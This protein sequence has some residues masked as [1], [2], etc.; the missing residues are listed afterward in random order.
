M[1]NW[2]HIK[3]YNWYKRPEA[4]P[5][6]LK[7]KYYILHLYNRN[8]RGADIKYNDTIKNRKGAVFLMWESRFSLNEPTRPEWYHWLTKNRCEIALLLCFTKWVKTKDNLWRL[9]CSG[10]PWAMV[11]AHHQ[12]IHLI[13]CTLFYK[14]N[15]P[16]HYSYVWVHRAFLVAT[17]YW[18]RK[19][20]LE[21]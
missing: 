18:L 8:Y 20:V 14:K 19:R 5:Y 1:D 2:Y 12:T 17:T 10:C 3:H 9:W 16:Y 7:V 15:T 21:N 13:V 11:I 6:N 4:K